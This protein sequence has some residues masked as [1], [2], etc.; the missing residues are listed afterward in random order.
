VGL[1]RTFVTETGNALIAASTA[2][3]KSGEGVYEGER[4]AAGE[5]EGRGTY[6][7]A[8]GNV[9]EGEWKGDKK[10]GNGTH[11][12]ADGDVY[13]GE[14]KRDEK[15]GIGTYR[16][17]D[18]DV[19]EG[20][21]K[22]GVKEGLGT[23][24]YVKEGGEAEVTRCRAG[25]PVGEGAWWSANRHRAWRLLDGELVEEIS[26][27]RAAAIAT[28]IG[29][30]VPSHRSNGSSG[31][32]YITPSGGYAFRFDLTD[33]AFIASMGGLIPK[34]PPLLQSQES[35]PVAQIALRSRSMTTDLSAGSM[36]RASLSA[37]RQARSAGNILK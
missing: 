35:A 12:Y 29:L 24:H 2:V 19:Y 21:Y 36:W 8:D 9:Y 4:N 1:Y 10:E 11:R 16:Y 34:E 37:H 17:A 22:G 30:P 15:D 25:D 3:G 20:E 33:A 14:W 28:R 26:L 6:R 5:K 31:V 7:F 18:G 23:Y 13:H 27:A 32:A